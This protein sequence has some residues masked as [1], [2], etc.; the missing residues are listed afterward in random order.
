MIAGLPERM[1]ARNAAGKSAELLLAHRGEVG[2]SIPA[3]EK[4]KVSADLLKQCRRQTRREG[5]KKF[6]HAQYFHLCAL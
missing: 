4:V 2:P 1:A 5:L 3:Q 6:G